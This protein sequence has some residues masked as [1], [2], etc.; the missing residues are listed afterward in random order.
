MKLLLAEDESAIAEAVADVL[1]YNKYLV[2]VVDNGEDA[3]RFIQL[4][5]YD[6]VILDIMMPKKDGIQVLKDIRSQGNRVPVIL[7]T[8][9]SQIEDRIA[10]LDAGADDY[11]PKPFAMGEL[12]ARVRAMLRRRDDF[13]PDII[14]CGDVSLN[15]QSSELSGN[16]KSFVL[17]KLEFRMMELFMLNKGI[18]ISSED[19]LAK[20]W[21][22]DT[23]A[24]L[25]TVWVY[26]S[27]LRKKLSAMSS[28]V[29]ITAKRNVGYTISV[30]EDSDD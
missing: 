25:G 16:G 22:L 9:K 10:G 28:K 21:G 19:L 27:Y 15:R 2:D 30:T 4:G 12:V 18:Y 8:A 11:L 20:V 24:E 5:D 1:R 23:D 3:V 14:T 29:E 17:P 26:I 13:T 7:L 6:G